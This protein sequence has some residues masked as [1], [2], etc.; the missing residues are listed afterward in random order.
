MVDS[1]A[2]TAAPS[3]EDLHQKQKSGWIT[4]ASPPLPSELPTTALF[5]PAA[6]SSRRTVDGAADEVAAQ[7]RKEAAPASMDETAVRE[8]QDRITRLEDSLKSGPQQQP[9]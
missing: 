3:L 6:S 1:A 9:E 5:S 4:E 8:L 7:R 2:T